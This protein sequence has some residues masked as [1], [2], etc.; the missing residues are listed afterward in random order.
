MN[1]SRPILRNAPF[2]RL[3]MSIRHVQHGDRILQIL[4]GALDSCGRHG[5]TW[6][7]VPLATMTF[8]LESLD[9]LPRME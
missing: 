2:D 3:S 7:I 6:D 1:S 8:N 4:D 5:N 9:S